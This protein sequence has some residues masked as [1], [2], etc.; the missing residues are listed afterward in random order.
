MSDEKYKTVWVDSEIIEAIKSFPL[1][2]EV[3]HCGIKF[4]VP[5]F[6][7]QVDCPKCGASLKLRATSASYE[8]EDVFDAVFLW[9]SRPEALEIAQ[10]RQK[11]IAEF[12]AE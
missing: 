5:P 8:I 2:T 10:A 12:K 4:S 3:E 7:I 9:L 1:T 11:T 6:E